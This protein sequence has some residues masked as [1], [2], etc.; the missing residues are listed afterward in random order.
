[1]LATLASIFGI[2]SIPANRFS[3]LL[4]MLIQPVQDVGN[5]VI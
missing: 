1:M 2:T 4:K 3:E 5:H